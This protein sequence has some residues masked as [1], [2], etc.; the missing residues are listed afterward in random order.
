MSWQIVPTVLTEMLKDPDP[1]KASRVMSAMLQM[2]KIN[3]KALK[4]AKGE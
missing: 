3:I 4:E 1:E 2:K